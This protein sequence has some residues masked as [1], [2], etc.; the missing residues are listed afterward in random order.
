MWC[1]CGRGEVY[2]GTGGEE[3]GETA[4]KCKLNEIFKYLKTMDIP[5]CVIN[6]LDCPK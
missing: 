1:V 4:V 6:F 2:E 5:I 3:G